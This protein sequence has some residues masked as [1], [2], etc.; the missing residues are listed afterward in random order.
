DGAHAAFADLLHELVGT[1]TASQTFGERP[2]PDLTMHRGRAV[3]LRL[4]RPRISGRRRV[5]Q[6]LF[7]KATGVL[8]GLEQGFD[9]P[10]QGGIAATRL[11]QEGGTLP[12]GLLQGVVEECL[13]VHHRPP[14]W[15]AKISTQI[16]AKG[17]EKASGNRRNYCRSPA[18]VAANLGL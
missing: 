15:V 12:G 6:R 8:I 5:Q 17:T 14:G 13:F 16:S 2:A 4:T 1:D 18:S 7:Q 11:P 3:V 10:A 9:A